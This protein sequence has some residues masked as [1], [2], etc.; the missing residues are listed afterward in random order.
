[1]CQR[2]HRIR[3]KEI[4]EQIV[5][6]SSV[7]DGIYGL[8]I[9]HMRSTPSVRRF[10]YFAFQMIPVFV[11]LHDDGRLSSFEG[12]SSCASSS[13]ASLLQVIDDVMSLALYSQVV[14]QTPQHVGSSKKQ[15]VCK[16]CFARQSI[17]SVIFLH[18]GMYWAGRAGPSEVVPRTRS[19]SFTAACTEQVEPA[20]LKWYREPG[21]FPSLRHVLSR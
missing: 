11:W 9:A 12:R 17:C 19:F 14:S 1:M 3:V 7:Q 6:F 21:H 5:Q 18:C 2:R 13:H 10:P 8:G 20:H 15:A 4:T 16:G